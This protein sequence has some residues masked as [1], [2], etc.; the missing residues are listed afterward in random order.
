[1]LTSDE[2]FVEIDIV[3]LDLQLAHNVTI[4]KNYAN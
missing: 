2:T 1:M 4:E 3:V